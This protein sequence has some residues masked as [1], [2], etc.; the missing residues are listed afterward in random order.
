MSFQMIK[1]FFLSNLEEIS[2][3]NI[4]QNKLS[5]LNNFTETFPV[6]FRS[7]LRILFNNEGFSS[8]Q[9]EYPLQ[10]IQKNGN[11]LSP[12]YPLLNVD[13]D[14][15][16]ILFR[17]IYELP[18]KKKFK[19]YLVDLVNKKILS[20]QEIYTNFSNLLKINKEFIRKNVYLFSENF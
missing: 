14:E 4:H 6:N 10:M 8:Y 2:A 9:S 15:N 20:I 19:V 11:I 5:R 17:N 12:I 3:K 13:A 1:Y 16:Y 18:I 7:N